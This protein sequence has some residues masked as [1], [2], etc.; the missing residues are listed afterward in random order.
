MKARG[1][2]VKVGPCLHGR[3]QNLFERIFVAGRATAAIVFLTMLPASCTSQTPEPTATYPAPRSSTST[4][5]VTPVITHTQTPTFTPISTPTPNLSDASIEELESQGYTQDDLIRFEIFSPFDGAAFFSSMGEFFGNVFGG[6]QFDVENPPNR[7]EHRGREGQVY[8][9]MQYAAPD[10]SNC[11]LLFFSSK[12]STSMLIADIDVSQLN[13]RINVVITSPADM[14][15]PTPLFCLTGDWGDINDNGLPEIPVT[16]LWGNNYTG[17]EVHIFE[18]NEDET[19]VDL[20][21]DL[22]GAMSHWYFNP[23]YSDQ[24]V[25]DLVWADHDCIYPQ[26]PFSFWVFDWDGEGF[27]DYTAS[28]FYDFSTYI[29]RLKQLVISRYGNPIH[30]GIDIGP[31]VSVLLMYDKMGQRD[32]GWE[33]FLEMVDI[34]NWQDTAADD[35]KWLEDDVAHFTSQYN[36]GAPFTPNDYCDHIS[37]TP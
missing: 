18:V 28:E 12:G 5:T 9:Y 13:E 27:S 4:Y 2:I 33:E 8:T 19:V 29:D 20:T 26:S 31:I 36:S 1:L 17:G 16:L 15:Y 22:P 30:P 23:A 32:K 14:M 21:E 24:M 6:P 35:L 25:V 7:L 34:A 10:G 3:Y 37:G 11:H